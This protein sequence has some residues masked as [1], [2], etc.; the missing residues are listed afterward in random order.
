MDRSRCFGSEV[1]C[2]YGIEN[3]KRIAEYV[4]NQLQDDILS[5]Q[6]TL[7]EYTYPFTGERVNVGKK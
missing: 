3:E 7:R 4:G 5:D 2:G 6:L 1:I